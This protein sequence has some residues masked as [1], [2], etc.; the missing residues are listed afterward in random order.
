MAKR[1]PMCAVCRSSHRAEV[2]LSLANDVSCRIVGNRYGL[3]KD[4]C[5]RHKTNHMTT[6]LKAR[7]KATGVNEPGSIMLEAN[8]PPDSWQIRLLV[9]EHPRSLLCCSRQSGKSTVTAALACQT[10]LFDPGLILIA[11]PSE[12]QS[13][14]LLRK[15]RDIFFDLDGVPDLVNESAL[16]LELANGS[17]IVALPGT[18]TT[19][20][21]YSAPKLI[22]IDEAARVPDELYQALLPMLAVSRGRFVALSTPHGRRG[23]FFECWEDG[24]DKFERTM[25]TATDC[26]RI[27]PAWLEEQKNTMGEW[28]FDQEYLCIFKDS[29]DAFF[30][31]ALIERALTNE[32]EPLWPNS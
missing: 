1:E 23:F 22:I 18:E 27:D 14:E 12:R 20:R 17:R 21:G 9:S 3:H 4:A 19:L 29:N 28:A 8:L 2:E 26:P 32:V 25:I 15:I 6:E 16:T 11:A 30:S 13:K 5:W 7:L 10:A 24:G 31:T